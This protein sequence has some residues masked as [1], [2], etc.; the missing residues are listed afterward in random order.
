MSNKSLSIQ[1]QNAIDLILTGK[2]DRQVA[3]CVGVERVTVNNWRN[4]K[5]EFI[6]ELNRRR[7]ELFDCEI[8]RL[9]CMITSSIDALSECIN[10]NNERIKLTAATTLLKLIGMDQLAL[11]K[12][13]VEP[14]IAVPTNQISDLIK[15]CSHT[16][17]SSIESK[18][19]H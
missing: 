8:D 14:D 7:N 12:R 6:G 18:S 5:P 9:R 1:Q 16:V 17:V 3:E 4:R 2:N 13:P 10:S 11:S 19:N 15:L